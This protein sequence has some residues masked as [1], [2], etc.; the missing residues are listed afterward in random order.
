MVKG[1]IMSNIMGG[2]GGNAGASHG[3]TAGVPSDAVFVGYNGMERGLN[4]AM[5]P[6]GLPPPMRP[7]SMDQSANY[8]HRGGGRGNAGNDSYDAGYRAPPM[9]P[10]HQDHQQMYPTQ[11]RSGYGYGNHGA[12]GGYGQ[13]PYSTASDSSSYGDYNGGYGSSYGSAAPSAQNAAYGNV[14]N[15]GAEPPSYGN[16]QIYGAPSVSRSGPYSGYHGSGY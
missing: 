14:G 2:P 6:P 10:S 15:A 16:S 13:Q 7:P 12:A 5:V 4:G 1:M 11:Q 3:S 9:Q 8:L